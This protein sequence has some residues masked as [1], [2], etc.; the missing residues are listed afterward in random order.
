[1]LAE[2]LGTLSH[3]SHNVAAVI[4]APAMNTTWSE[5][6]TTLTYVVYVQTDL[7]KDSTVLCQETTTF[8]TTRLSSLA[9]PDT[10]L[11]TFTTHHSMLV[12]TLGFLINKIFTICINMLSQSTAT[13]H[14][15]E[16]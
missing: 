5:L 13:L 4:H 10:I 12:R 9:T 3:L 16:T 2:T 11:N 7:V 1:M 15:T 6:S 14:N 8:T